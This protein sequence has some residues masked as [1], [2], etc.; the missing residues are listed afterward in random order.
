MK[1]PASRNAP[2]PCGSGRRYKECHGALAEGI[3]STA[4]KFDA[5]QM[6]AQALAAVGR[7]DFAT[8]ERAARA[9][10]TADPRHPDAAH[11]LALVAL[12]QNR[13]GNAIDACDRAIAVLPD[14]AAFHASRAL[15][16]AADDA[17]NWTLLGP[18]VARA[19]R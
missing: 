4:A 16:L 13:F 1:T 5:R 7:S 6:I 12:A 15:A 10:E 19:G 14:H 17:A 18:R 9:V 2:C 8:A 11:V 3:L